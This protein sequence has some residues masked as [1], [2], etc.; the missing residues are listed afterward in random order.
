[1]ASIYLAIKIHSPKKVTIN[2]I[3]STGN[4][5]I[6]A[7]HIEAMELSIMQG[8]QWHLFSPTS[9]TFIENLYPL[10]AKHLDHR[11]SDMAD[12]LEFVRFLTNLSVCA[13]PFV[14]AK[15]SSI[16]VAAVLY[17]LEYFESSVRLQGPLRTLLEGLG[18]DS[19][20]EEVRACGMLL[21]RVHQLAIPNVE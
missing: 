5:L 20:A 21:W 15:L 9:A 4:G 2:S 1:M 19:R 16:A 8:L 12:S 7:K 18:V 6:T 11:G 13:Y 10:L 17:S 3:A 14:S